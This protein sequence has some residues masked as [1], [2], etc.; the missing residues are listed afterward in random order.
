MRPRLYG[1]L[2]AN[3]SS[4]RRMRPQPHIHRLLCLPRRT[5]RH[6][7]LHE[8]ARH[9]NRPRRSP[10]GVVC[11]KD[12]APAGARAQ[13]QSRACTGGLHAR[14]VGSTRAR[15]A[16]EAEG[17]GAARGEDTRTHGKGSA[18]G[19]GTM[20]EKKQK[21]ENMCCICGVWEGI[22]NHLRCSVQYKADGFMADFVRI[23][24]AGCEYEKLY[25]YAF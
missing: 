8:T 4:L 14:V 3:I 20:R 15:S 21:N 13:G 16:V 18:E 24:K 23:Q 5:P 2:I 11:P 10:R 25:H 6:E 1:T 7:Q 12:R 9:T 22:E 19:E 17:D